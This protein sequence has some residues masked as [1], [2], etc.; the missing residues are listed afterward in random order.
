MGLQI[1]YEQFENLIHGKV[2]I[3]ERSGN[4]YDSLINMFNILAR[5]DVTSSRTLAFDS[6]IYIL[7]E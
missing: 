1:M 6:L 7:K 4:W 5:S 3:D 2:G